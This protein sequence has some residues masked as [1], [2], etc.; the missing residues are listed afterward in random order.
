MPNVLPRS[1]KVGKS[2]TITADELNINFDAEALARVAGEAIAKAHRERIPQGVKADGS[3]SNRTPDGGRDQILGYETGRLASSFKST[4]SGNTAKAT[5]DVRPK[6][7]GRQRSH[8]LNAGRKKNGQTN[9]E[10]L[11]FAGDKGTPLSAEV[12]EALSREMDNQVK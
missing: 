1:R 9:L 11:L 4:V 3:G 2:I 12:D 10:R 5:A 6:G 8:Y 7:I